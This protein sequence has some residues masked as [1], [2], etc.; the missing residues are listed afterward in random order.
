ML[1]TFMIVGNLHV[2]H[3]VLPVFGVNENGIHSMV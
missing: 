3:C 1:L 2:I